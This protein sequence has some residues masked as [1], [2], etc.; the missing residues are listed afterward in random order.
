MGVAPALCDVRGRRVPANL[1]C[2]LF[3]FFEGTAYCLPAVLFVGISEDCVCI[4]GAAPTKTDSVP[5]RKRSIDGTPPTLYCYPGTYHSVP[6][7]SC[8]YYA[9]NR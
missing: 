9:D 2:A 5:S 1:C 4:A 8:P 3:S 7:Y 6:E